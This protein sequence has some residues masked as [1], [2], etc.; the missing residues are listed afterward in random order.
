MPSKGSSLPVLELGAEKILWPIGKAVEVF[1]KGKWETD[2]KNLI[3]VRVVA[4]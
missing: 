4:E 3:L 1:W 2:V